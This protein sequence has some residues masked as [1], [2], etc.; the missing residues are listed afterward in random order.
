VSFLGKE[1]IGIAIR[2]SWDS[3]WC[4][5]SVVTVNLYSS[6]LL[7]RSKTALVHEH[8]LQHLMLGVVKQQ[9]E[10]LIPPV[11]YSQ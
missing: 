9:L 5:E 1:S 10:V 7:I 3:V 8:T 11:Q 4:M 2:L 6:N